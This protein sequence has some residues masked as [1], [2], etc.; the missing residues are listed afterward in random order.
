MIEKE[1]SLKEFPISQSKKL[2][3]CF[4]T[5]KYVYSVNILN[6]VTAPLTSD[7]RELLL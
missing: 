5:I 1:H 3:K 6:C 7:K 4:F 2:L